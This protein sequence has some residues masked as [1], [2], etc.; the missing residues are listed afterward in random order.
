MIEA[1]HL[2]K[3]FTRQVDKRKK[4]DFNAVDDIS[5]TVNDGELV[6]ILGPNGA[7]KTTL[8]RMLATLMT[9]TSGEIRFS[10]R[11]ESDTD[12][13]PSSSDD[14]KGMPSVEMIETES[15]SE[16]KKLIKLETPIE[17]R[18]HIGYLSANTKLYERFSVRETM[19]MFGETYGMSENEIN[20]R[21]DY[22]VEVLDLSSF[23]DNRV[24]KLSTGQMQRTQIARCLIHD[25]EI[26]IFDEPTLG[27]DVISSTGIID[28]MKGEKTRGKTILYSTHYMEEAQYLCDRV[29]LLD[30]GKIICEDTPAHLMESTNSDTMRDAFFSSLKLW[31]ERMAYH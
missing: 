23:I 27:L 28:F 20:E 14:S 5:L 25:P 2:V 29:L 11:M 8:L 22:L 30:H 4:E 9:P 3:T 26:Y 7:G 6:G 12:M 21:T 16:I 15:G 31:G 13:L 19:R 18:R 1:K 24:A 10:V 17:I